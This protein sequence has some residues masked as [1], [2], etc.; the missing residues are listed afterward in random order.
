[1]LAL[2]PDRGIV[3]DMTRVQFSGFEFDQSSG[4]LTNR[5]QMVRLR[6]KTSQLLVCLLNHAG[7]IMSR[8]ELLDAV[9]SD[10]IVSENTLMQSVRELRAAL[11]DDAARPQFIETLHGRGYRWIAEKPTELAEPASDVE[12][13]VQGGQASRVLS[14]CDPYRRPVIGGAISLVAIAALIYAASQLPQGETL[15]VAQTAGADIARAQDARSRGRSDLAEQ[16]YEAALLLQ[17]NDPDAQAGLATILYEAGD[18]ARAM[19]IATV[20]IEAS[21]DHPPRRL[22]EMHIVAGRIASGRGQLKEA[23]EHFLAARTKPGSNSFAPVIHAAALSG[24]SYVY[25]D[26]GKITEYLSVQTEAVDPLLMAAQIESYAEGLLSA[27]TMVHPT[28]DQGWNVARLR[29][30]LKVFVEID[31]INGIARANA[32]LGGNRG[33]SYEERSKHLQLALGHY[34]DYGHLPGEADVL[35]ILASLEIEQLHGQEALQAVKR[36]EAILQ[37]L[38]ASRDLAAVKYA[39][40]LALMATMNDPRNPPK[41][42][43]FD[44]ALSS[45]G[46]AISAYDEL[47]VVF[48]SIAPRLHQAIALYDMSRADE[49]LPVFQEVAGRYRDIPF[50]H[51]EVAARMGEALCLASLGQSTGAEQLLSDLEGAMPEITPALLHVRDL[52]AKSQQDQRGASVNSYFQV[53]IT[54]ERLLAQTLPDPQD[55]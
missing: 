14:W 23:E 1:M 11:G 28:F 20:G 48:D 31:D 17:P 26:Q 8:E 47:G 54:A 35:A 24:L 34:R 37:Q 45:F 32:A 42:P 40:G 16:Y 30:A 5:S 15:D 52:M 27:G 39:T 12:I 18:W 49:A 3:K 50:P 6:P 4:A 53:V 46:E 7:Q 25:A 36:R 22:A 38:V 51:G 55:R 29:Q 9:W 13:G 10:R 41:R 2:G 43:R 19:K 21:R 44:E 33:L